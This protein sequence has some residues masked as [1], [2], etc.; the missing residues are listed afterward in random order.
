M[1]PMSRL[2]RV[3]V[4]AVCGV[5][6]LLSVGADLFA[7]SPDWVQEAIEH[8]TRDPGELYYFHGTHEDCPIGD[9]HAQ[10]IIDAVLTSREIRPRYL[11]LS[12]AL[13]DQLY[14]DLSVS[15]LDREDGSFVYAIDAYFAI[16]SPLGGQRLLIAR[17]FGR[18]G[19]GDRTSILQAIQE[20]VEDAADAFLLANHAR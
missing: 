9:D 10:G 13:S 12:R 11:N 3:L 16:H 15:C 14:L 19:L 20:S 1:A 17:R 6:F 18:L 2:S 7:D 8:A 5:A 4:A